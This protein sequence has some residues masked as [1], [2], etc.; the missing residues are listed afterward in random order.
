M[1]N[2]RLLQSFGLIDE[3]Y[4]KEAEPKMKAPTIASSKIFARVACLV[5]VIALSLY[6]FIPFDKSGPKLTAY[7]DS[8]YFPLIETI[9]NYRYR[10]SP[11]KNNFQ[12][13][14][15]GIGGLFDGFLAKG[16]ADAPNDMNGAPGESSPDGGSPDFG[17]ANGNYQETTDNQVEGVIEA[18][19]MKRTDKYIFRLNDTSLVVYDINK[20]QTRKITEFKLPHVVDDHKKI[21]N[22]TD[23]YLS[24]DAS[25]I[26]VVEL[27]TKSNI[28]FTN[29]DK[30][31]ITALDISDI[32][33]IKVKKS[34][35]ID[36]MY[37]TSRMLDGKLILISNYEINTA[38]IDYNKPETFVP[39]ITDGD[40]TEC[41][42]I[43]SIIY[44][45]SISSTKYS[46]V[47]IMDQDS[48]EVLST[49]ALLDFDDDVFVSRNNIY[50]TREYLQKTVIDNKGLYVNKMMS[51]IVV[52]G[53]ADGVIENK[54]IFTV[55]GT[56]KDQYSLDEYDGHLRVVSST[57]ER[58]PS[59]SVNYENVDLTVFNLE[60]GE[61]VAKV[62]SFAPNGEEATS[63]RFD[64]NTAY[65]CTAEV[66][67]FCDPVYFFDLS[68]YSNITY[69]DTGVIDG[70]SS[71]L[72]QLGDG[73]LLGIGEKSWDENKIE[74]YAER[75]GQ[76]VSVAEYVFVGNYASEYKAYFIDRENDTVGI[77]VSNFQTIRNEYG[78]D[79][80]WYEDGYLLFCLDGGGY[81]IRFIPIYWYNE[82]NRVRAFAD[83]GYLYILT[84]RG[85]K[86]EKYI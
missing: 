78:Q 73:Y 76:V 43:E 68:D 8:E 85:I 58:A 81:S 7:E 55:E 22:Y 3:K 86:V 70:F 34:V 32:S 71:S 48:L 52:L 75:D 83:D 30:V 72:I 45:E 19:L 10:P 9:A 6:L 24:N 33:D 59:G 27:Y 47:A 26:I 31:G 51:D 11:Y 28:Y 38:D 1:K 21:S 62:E 49:K 12:W 63:V 42:D 67:T 39:N 14:S 66:R 2:K 60:S 41:V 74:V 57:T 84:D 16:D 56:V 35:V 50:V 4:V 46:I 53:Y 44:P 36:G 40:V 29:T 37:N 65:V 80:I 13:L 5:I 25:T 77:P 17:E 54:G 79:S 15:A 69:T 23:M 20:E 64:K 18:D 82:E 61:K